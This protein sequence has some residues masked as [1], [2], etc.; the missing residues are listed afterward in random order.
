MDQPYQFKPHERPIIPGSPFNPDHP[1]RRMWA[2]GAIAL[3]AGVTGGLGNALVTAN[4][5]F[6]QGTLGLTAEEAAWIPG[7]YVMT[8]VCANL[9]LVKFRQ[10]F[11]LALFV[12]LVLVGYALT[13]LIHLF[14]H[15][16]WSAILIRAAS[17]IAGSG[18]TTLCILAMFPGDAAAQTALRHPDRHQHPAACDSAG[19]R[20]GAGPARMGRL[21]DGLLFRIR[22]GVADAGGGADPAAA[23]ERAREGVR[24][25][26]FPDGWAAVSGHRIAVRGARHGTHIM[27]DPG[28]VDRLGIDRRPAADQ[29][30]HLR[31]ASPR[32]PVAAD[33]LARPMG[34]HPDRRRSPCASVSCWPSR[35]FG[36]VGL[37][38]SLGMGVDQF[39]TL[40]FIVTLASLAGL[41]TAIFAFRPQTP[42]RPIQ[43]A[44]LMIAVGRLPR[45]QRDQPYAASQRL[46]EPGPDRFR[47]AA[48]HRPGDGDRRVAYLAGGTAELHQ[49][50]RRCSARRKP[51]RTDRHG[52]VRHVPDGPR[53]VPFARSGRADPADQSGRRGPP[54]RSRAP[55]RWRGRPIRRFVL[56]KALSLLSQQ[57]T[58]EANI[59]AYNDVFLLIGVLA[60]LLFLWGVTIEIRHA[61][62]RRDFA[63]RPAGAGAW[64]PWRNADT[65]GRTMQLH[66]PS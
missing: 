64:R 51:R 28:A 32:E 36:S 29:R 4:L 47:G 39:Q 7:V 34:H 53:E 62:A 56:P 31:R 9:L 58:R 10:Q 35:S 18:L 13:T 37:L 52:A 66:D 26:R 5:S 8:N 17:G 16:F 59:L 41:A 48:V 2:Y 20:A 44:C 45:R 11:G 38:S 12:R 50:D 21:A 63:D 61:P 14:I 49:L 54:V 42:A 33:P 15:D 22:A 3:L 57:V 40:Y 25:D 19:A 30:R 27:V 65:E 60:L 24:A 23:A 6:F 55:G 1:T 43:I 46:S